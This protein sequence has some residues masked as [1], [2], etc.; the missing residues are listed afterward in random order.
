MPT[1]QIV[2]GSTRPNRLGLPVATW[3]AERARLHGGFDVQLVDLLEV[4]LPPLDEPAHPRLG[5]YTHEH[6]KRWSATVAAA[7]AFA[8][9]MPEYNHFPP[10]PLVNA[11]D[12]L[13]AEWAYK[14]AAIVSYGGVSGGT[15]AATLLKPMLTALKV[16][17]I[18]ES[19]ILPL[20]AQQ[21][22]GGALRS[23]PLHE[24][25]ATAMLD[26]LRRWTDALAVLREPSPRG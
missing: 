24:Q 12:Y 11:I 20:V 17:P 6:T 19:V 21:M 18:P 4:G 15:R 2:L 23:T 25:A 9:V 3:F 14:P 7:D 1:L 26:E 22:E 10:G 5:Q 8:F 13:V 16:M